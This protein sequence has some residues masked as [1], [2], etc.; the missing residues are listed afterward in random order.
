MAEV[1]ARDR[2][3]WEVEVVVAGSP[4]R[5]RRAGEND[6]PE[7]G[8]RR[9]GDPR[10]KGEQLGEGARRKPLLEVRRCRRRRR[11]VRRV[12]LSRQEDDVGEECLR[13]VP[14][15]LHA[16]Q[17]A[18][19]R[20]DVAAGRAGAEGVGLDERRPGAREGI[21]DECARPRVASQEDLCELRH[22]LAEVRVESVDVLRPLPLRELGLRPGE[23]QVD[24]RVEIG[25][26]LHGDSF[27]VLGDRPEDDVQEGGQEHA[28]GHRRADRVA[29]FLARAGRE[30]PAGARRG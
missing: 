15:G 28:A 3:A 9:R 26:S 2:L 30:R 5:A 24:S 22:E 8:V 6:V 12:A 18:V 7:V 20:R 4:S 14:R 19:E 13:F 11:P 27:A 1:V 25:L 17:K 29:R 16:G 21:P 23:L 10:P